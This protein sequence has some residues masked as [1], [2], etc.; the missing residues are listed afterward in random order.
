MLTTLAIPRKGV[1]RWEWRGPASRDGVLGKQ[2]NCQVAVTIIPHGGTNDTVSVPSAYQLYLPESWA[3]D[4]ERRRDAGVPA[5]V[6]FRTKGEISLDLTKALRQ[7]G[8]PCAPVVADAAYGAV[9]A[10]RPTDSS[11][12][13]LRGGGDR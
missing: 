1:I 13:S 2:E 11:E 12:G 9:T 8:L 7:E 10:W 6:L 3:G 5:D 4:A